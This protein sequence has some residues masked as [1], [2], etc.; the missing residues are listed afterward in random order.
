MPAPAAQTMPVD[1]PD[2]GQAAAKGG[3]API[4]IGLLLPLR[5]DVLGAP[6]DALRAGFMAAYE[7]DKS[8]FVIN[9]IDTGDAPDEALDAYM[10]GVK[11][12]DL[13]VGPLPRSA[14]TAIAGS[15]AVSKP[16]IAL[17]H[18]DSRSAEAAIPP[19][20]LVVGLSIE[21]EARQVAQWAAAEHPGV[22]ALVVSGATPWQRRLAG[23]FADQWKLLG[24]RVQL[25]ELG[26]TNGF[27]N[28]PGIL[29][30][31]Q[32]IDTEQPALMFAALDADQLRQVRS[33]VG[34]ELPAYG[35][36]SV[37]PGAGQASAMIDLDG[38]R[39]LDMPWEVSPDHSAVMVYPRWLG[40]SRTLDL[41]RLYAL[42][43]DAYRIARQIALKPNT[44]FKMDGVTGRLAV[45]FG[46]SGARFERI[47]QG[48]TY[49]GGAFK[50]VEQRR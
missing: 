1:R 29:Q 5:S 28:E 21:D 19:N 17:N 41:D 38:T 39:L 32:R 15:G 47:L 37:N 7:R 18:P 50:L 3:A 14:V 44:P 31:K 12:N 40:G 27:L 34:P 24:N 9:L 43:I 8:G 16:T 22:A 4:R 33:I 30:L 25:V 23:A 35:A 13:I 45:D 11:M 48:A 49:Q 26:A 42:G 36:S 6:A 46:P 10:A 20:M 2:T